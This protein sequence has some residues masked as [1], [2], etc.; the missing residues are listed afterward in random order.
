MGESKKR[1]WTEMRD[2]GFD[3]TDT[4]EKPF[5]RNNVL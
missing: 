4:A 5:G 1:Q 3:S 2:V